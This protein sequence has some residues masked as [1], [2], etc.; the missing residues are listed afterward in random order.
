MRQHDIYNLQEY[1]E[2]NTAVTVATGEDGNPM[3]GERLQNSGDYETQQE[4]SGWT[5]VAFC[6]YMKLRECK[7]R[8]I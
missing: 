3:S 4:S 2:G 6:E 1:Q 5:I 7:L 8:E